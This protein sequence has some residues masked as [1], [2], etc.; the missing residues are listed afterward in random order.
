MLKKA[1]YILKQSI[2]DWHTKIDGYFKESGFKR[3][4]SEPTLY[5]NTKGDNIFLIYLYVYDLI[6]IGSSSN[7]NDSFK[8]TMMSEFEMKDL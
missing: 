3:S 4:K 6:Y 2:I 1:F 5:F 7:L 8:D